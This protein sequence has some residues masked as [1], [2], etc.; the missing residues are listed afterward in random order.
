MSQVFLF[1]YSLGP[2]AQD[3]KKKKNLTLNKCQTQRARAYEVTSFRST[4][5][6]LSTETCST[7]A[8]LRLERTM[9]LLCH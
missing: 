3:H 2:R 7:R 8:L 9:N 1:L 5:C 6:E 4:D